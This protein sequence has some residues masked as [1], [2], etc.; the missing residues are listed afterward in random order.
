MVFKLK[1]LWGGILKSFVFREKTKALRFLLIAA[2][3]IA[4]TFSGCKGI[5]KPMSPHYKIKAGNSGAA[6]V[7]E[8]CDSSSQSAESSSVSS[9]NNISSARSTESSSI[10]TENNISSSESVESSPVT[11]RVQS[12]R[13]VSKSAI[14]S[15][16][17]STS[18]ASSQTIYVKAPCFPSQ[19]KAA[20]NSSTS[21]KDFEYT[22]KNLTSDQVKSIPSNSTYK[23]IISKFGKSLN[24]DSS[25]YTIYSVDNSKLL[26]LIYPDINGI[27]PLS[28]EELL[29]STIT[30]HN[31]Y[32]SGRTGYCIVLRTYSNGLLVCNP[33]AD[34]KSTASLYFSLL[35]VDKNTKITFKDGS[36]A[37]INDIHVND[38]IVVTSYGWVAESFPTQMNVNHIVILK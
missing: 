35:T 28:G 29:S 38:G 37:T 12:K 17:T 14:K 6:L 27:C 30:V 18:V 9:E 13:I 32:N 36:S 7:S 33:F 26:V 24:Y 5:Y 3:T 16:G 1:N 34:I 15:I 20:G 22:V 4:F 21:S 10:S 8:A 11:N 23:Y 25:C 31:E 19:N 2:L